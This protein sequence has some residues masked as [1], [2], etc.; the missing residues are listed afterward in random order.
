MSLIIFEEI[1]SSS[2]GPRSQ[3]DAHMARMRA[4]GITTNSDILYL[5]ALDWDLH[6][7]TDSIAERQARLNQAADRVPADLLQRSSI[8][9]TLVEAARC[10]QQ[11]ADAA[12]DED[13]WYAAAERAMCAAIPSGKCKLS[14]SGQSVIFS[15][16][17]CGRHDLS[18][19]R[20]GFAR[21]QMRS[22]GIDVVLDEPEPWESDDSPIFS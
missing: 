14:R 11:Q 15:E 17:Q 7:S 6:F 8:A 4:D 13:R 21:A 10:L 20:I 2:M 12:V 19:G 9:R 18:E 3:K 1:P 16:P 22:A 5:R